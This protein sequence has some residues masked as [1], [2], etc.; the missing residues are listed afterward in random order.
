M[1]TNPPKE[2]RLLLS[3]LVMA[4]GACVGAFLGSSLGIH[5]VRS[6]SEQAKH[7]SGEPDS[8]TGLV[9]III[10]SP[11]VG[12]VLGALPGLVALLIVGLRNDRRKNSDWA[13]YYGE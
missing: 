4:I 10:G 1:K 3:F 7:A 2:I 13:A 12:F 6:I 8:G 11:M 5:A 9:A